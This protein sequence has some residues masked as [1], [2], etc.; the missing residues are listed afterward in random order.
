M[1]NRQ[2]RP[3]VRRMVRACF[4]AIAVAAFA[5]C[6]APK[7]ARPEEASAQAHA[8]PAPPA[9]A[10]APLRDPLAFLQA[11]ERRTAA[12]R[13]YRCRLV[14]QERLG[15]FRQLQPAEEL[16]AAFRAEPLAVKF[17]WIDPK[18]DFAQA[19]YLAGRHDDKVLMLPRRG[20]FGLKPM[21]ARFDPADAVTFGK[22]R[23]PI[24]DFGVHRMLARTLRRIA[25]SPRYGGCKLRFVARA[26]VEGRAVECVEIQYP[27]GDPW[28][29]KRQELFFSTEDGMPLGT[30][31]WLADGRLD[32]RYLYL[33]LRDLSEPLTDTAFEIAGT[34]SAVASPG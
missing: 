28:P 34:R 33:D 32:A 30:A 15:L 16:T 23:N 14:R 4:T 24:T 2:S 21:T 27:A 9:A 31:L 6:T 12:L 3:A 25:E 18:S 10:S 17:D 1:R 13:Q 5:G 8:S 22:A 26:I 20:L 11:A 7:A 29:N 19:A